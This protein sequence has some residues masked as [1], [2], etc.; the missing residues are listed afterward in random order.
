MGAPGASNIV[1]PD[2]FGDPGPTD[3]RLYAL[4]LQLQGGGLADQ[5]SGAPDADPAP[6]GALSPSLMAARVLAAYNAAHPSAAPADTPDPDAAA[7]M[8]DA[9]D[10]VAPQSSDVEAVP[11]SSVAEPAAA[12]VATGGS[13]NGPPSQSP[14]PALDPAGQF[15]RPELSGGPDPLV[16]ALA[17]QSPNENPFGL[18]VDPKTGSVS[19]LRLDV[20]GDPLDPNGPTLEP[21]TPQEKQSY[22]EWLTGARANYPLG[23]ISPEEQ[24]LRQMQAAGLLPGGR[25]LPNVQGLLQQVSRGEGT[26][27][28]DAQAQGFKSGYDAVYQYGRYGLPPR[29]LTDMSLDEIDAY[30]TKMLN[31][32]RQEFAK[33]GQPNRHGS[34]PVGK[35]QF[36]QETLHSLRNTLHLTGAEKLTPQLQEQFAR[37]LLQRDELSDYVQGKITADRFQKKMRKTWSSIEAPD[38]TPPGKKLAHGTSTEDFRNALST[39]ERSGP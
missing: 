7:P 1:W 24:N 37:I 34:S 38:T 9:P 13:A 27:D 25:P 23:A 33:Q 32:E 20:G 19:H 35:Y 16:A 21:A 28:A 15:P 22:L 12:Q 14:S 6:D 8:V 4:A 3:P 31:A 11:A 2:S 18:I 36:T 5:P 26:T 10:A 17:G 30:Q 29:D 39:V